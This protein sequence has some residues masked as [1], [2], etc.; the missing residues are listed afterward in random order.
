MNFLQLCQRLRQETGI[1]D[2]GPSQVTGQTGDMKRLV[3]WIQESWLR[4]QSSRND[5]GWMWTAD[6]QVL[7]AGNS[8]LT[9][10]DTVERV[11]PGTLTIG[12]HELVEIDY[13]D[14]RRLYRELSRGRPCQYA[15]RP[16]GVVAFSAQA[17]QDYT[18][19]YEAYKT[20]AYFTEGIEVPGM[21]P[22]FHMLIVWGAL[23]EYAIYDEAG[24]LYQKG[25]SNYDTL[26]AE[27]SL[28]QEPRMEFAGP[29][30]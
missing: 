15:V 6:S 10:P 21:P 13:R 24:E 20:P 26:F 28:D 12:N 9:L 7:G 8:T 17:D 3:D 27:L 30:A 25:R 22:R 4:I 11:I 29:L 5:W 19:A 2:S 1:A 23:M 16:D 18:V 14:Y